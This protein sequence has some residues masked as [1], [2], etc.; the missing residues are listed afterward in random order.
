M[1][2]SRKAVRRCHSATWRA[3]RAAGSGSFF[4][5]IRPLGSTDD[6]SRWDRAAD[7]PGKPRCHLN[8]TVTVQ[9]RVGSSRAQPKAAL[10]AVSHHS[11]PV[12]TR[13]TRSQHTPF[14][15]TAIA[16]VQ[17]AETLVGR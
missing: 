17:V 11:F 7:V 2:V 9:R 8:S 6:T 14:P 4:P 5:V 12:S 10:A 13:V 16:V 3:G 1:R 15:R